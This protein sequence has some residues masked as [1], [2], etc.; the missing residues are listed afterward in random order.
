MNFNWFSRV[1]VLYFS[2]SLSVSVCWLLTI[3]AHEERVVSGGE[4]AGQQHEHAGGAQHEAHPA[5]HHPLSSPLLRGW[6]KGRVNP[7]FVLVSTRASKRRLNKG[8][9]RFHNHREAPKIGLSPWLWNFVLTV[10]WSCNIY[11][12]QLL[13][14]RW[15][16]TAAAGCEGWT[17]L[18]SGKGHC[19]KSP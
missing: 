13:T 7:C 18:V 19:L 9:R 15:P 8:S 16:R 14:G 12:L 1:E 17:S 4:E 2:E 5:A 3:S 11:N 6:N 10:I